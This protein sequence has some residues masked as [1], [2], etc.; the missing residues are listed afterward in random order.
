MKRISNSDEAYNILSEL[1]N[2]INNDN[3][4]NSLVKSD[5]LKLS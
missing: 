1:G 5:E 4:W 2:N 3:I